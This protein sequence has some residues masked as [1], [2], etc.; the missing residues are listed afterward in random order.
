M[1]HPKTAALTGGIASGKSTVSRMF[2]KLGAYVLDADVVAR[3]VVEPEQPAWQ[4]IV[5]HFG[6]EILLADGHLDRKRLGA[7]VFQQ[8][9][10]RRILER[11]IHPRVIEQ[12]NHQ[13]HL[14]HQTEHDRIIIVDVPLLI[15]A[16]M[17]T[18][19]ATVIVVYA[20]E[21]T[22]LQRLMSREQLSEHAAR[23]RLAAQMPLSE[24]L[25]YATHII[26]NDGTLAQTQQ[27]VQAIYQEMLNVEC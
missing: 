11:M 13:E 21:A 19:Y 4:E 6:H 24:K 8:P 17:H 18:D 9:D 25:N 27:Q 3:Q 12:I 22:Q 2:Q 5:A 14:L 15:E 7:I 20:S 23:Q 16:S 1:K 10:E 26:S